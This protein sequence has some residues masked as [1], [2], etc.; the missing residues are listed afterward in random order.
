MKL[1]VPSLVL[2]AVLLLFGFAEQ[3]VSIPETPSTTPITARTTPDSPGKTSKERQGPST[4]AG[5]WSQPVNGLSARL[6]VSY[7]EIKS[8]KHPTYFHYHKVILEA[9]NVGAETVSFI[10]QPSFSDLAIRDAHGK[11]LH[12]RSH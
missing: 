9:K 7:E 5:E 2:M 11:E 3:A 6:L 8:E 12:G 10:N 1:A 4:T